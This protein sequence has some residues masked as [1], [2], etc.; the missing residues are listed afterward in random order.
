VRKTKESV[1]RGLA[2]DMR[3]AYKIESALA[4]EVFSSDDATEGPKA[5]KEKRA[6]VWTG[7]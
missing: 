3:E 7:R 6:P 1:L 2:T 5:F 4:A